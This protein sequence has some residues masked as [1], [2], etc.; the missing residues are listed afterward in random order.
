MATTLEHRFAGQVALVTGGGSGIGAAVAH[1]L[2]AEGCAAVHVGD[3]NAEG[4]RTVASVIKGVAHVVDV[5]DPRAVDAVVSS[6]LESEGRIDVVI[7]TAGVD[8]PDAKAR[9]LEAQESGEP[10]DVLTRLD[11]AAWRRVMAVNLDGTFHVLRAAVRAMRPRGRGAIVTVGS[12]AAFDTLTGYPHYAAS[13]AGVHALSQA[14]AKEAIAFGIRVNTVAPGPVDTPM[15]ARTPDAVRQKMAESG[16]SGYATPEELAD[17]ICYL[18][19]PA[20]SNVV[21]AVLLSNGG[22]FTV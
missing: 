3:L 10:V 21:G 20:A 13:K 11:D 22:R 2:A 16:A 5:T 18:A 1:L 12:S 17:N 9:I 19:S 15:A 14:V 8:D 4:V 6:V 7:H